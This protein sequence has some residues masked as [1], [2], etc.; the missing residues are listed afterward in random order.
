MLAALAVACGSDDQTVAGTG[1]SSGIAGSAGS[2]GAA[3]TGNGGSAGAGA[4]SGTGGSGA[5][6]AGGNGGAGGSGAAGTGGNSG[7]SNA[8]SGGTGPGATSTR[9]VDL[10]TAGDYVILA[11]TG[12][13]SVPTSTITGSL[14]VSPAAATSITGFG[15][16]VDST[17]VFAS[18]TQ[19]IG[20]VYAA[21]Y[22]VPT[23][24][25][26]TTAIGDMEGAFS[27]AAGRAADTTEL[28]AG[29]LTGATLTPGVYQWGTGLLIPT[30][31]TLSGNANAVW[32][33]QVAQDLT[34]SDGTSVVLAGGAQAKNIFWQVS[35]Q[36]G[37]GTTVHFEGVILSQTAI[38][39]GTGA[40][41]DGR[42]LAQTAVS[43][44]S[45]TVVEAAE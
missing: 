33:F 20:K 3:A 44:E 19:V 22:G 15:L 11:K 27:D 21:D 18:S 32:I 1:E 42:L 5:A 31:L 37:L 2:A 17:N 25:N 14:G 30:N 34:M 39:L 45:S 28:G 9:P 24:S 8:G 38:T 16:T 4:G 43:L 13:S 7:G 10:G 35:G 23:P 6:A 36:V 41:I 40:S 26:L 29:T 12:I